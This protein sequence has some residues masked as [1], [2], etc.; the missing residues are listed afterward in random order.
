MAAAISLNGASNAEAGPRLKEKERGSSRNNFPGAVS[1][2]CD[3]EQQTKL[4]G[5]GFVSPYA[6]M[7]DGPEPEFRGTRRATVFKYRSTDAATVPLLTAAGQPLLFVHFFQPS[8][9]R[10]FPITTMSEKPIVAAHN[11]GLMNPSAAIG[12]DAA[13]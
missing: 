13:L 2:S 12:I 11:T 3:S 5:G 1:N 9:R 10:A 7:L 6:P 8:S 4:A